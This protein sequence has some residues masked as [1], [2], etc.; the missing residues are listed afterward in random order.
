MVYNLIMTSY[1]EF[2]ATQKHISNQDFEVMV[3]DNI[4]DQHH[5]DKVYEIINNASEEQTRIQPW[6]SH[7]VWDVSLGEEIEYRINEVVKNS[8][9]DHLVLKK[10]YSFARYSPKFG[11]RAKLFPHYDTRPSQRVTFDIQLKTSEPWALVVEEDVYDLQ[12]NQALVF[13]GTQ[14]IHWRENKQIADDAEIDMIFCHLEYVDDMLLDNG[15]EEVLRERA[16]FLINKTGISN[17][18]EQLEV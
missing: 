2:K 5:I 9:G 8:L 1:K 13:A 12:D 14:Q 6:A 11:Y 10:D 17:L 4:F 7:K 15:Q 16:N 18:E 3:V